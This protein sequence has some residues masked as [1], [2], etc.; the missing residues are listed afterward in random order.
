MDG[1]KDEALKCRRLAENYLKEGNKERAFKFL[2]KAQKLYPSKEVEGR[3]NLRGIW[4]RRV[5][6]EL[7]IRCRNRLKY[8]YFSLLSCTSREIYQ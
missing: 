8:H 5:V 6:K 2:H 7:M 1:N 3:R 4:N